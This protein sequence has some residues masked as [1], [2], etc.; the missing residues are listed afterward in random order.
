MVQIVLKALLKHI[1]NKDEVICGNQH[2]FTKGKSYLTNLMTFYDGITHQYI[3]EK[4]MTV[5]T[6]T[7]AKHLTLS[8]ITS[9]GSSFR[10]YMCKFDLR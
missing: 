3:K 4:Q 2:G 6:W 5:S 9:Y 1:E 8:Y 10:M 7:S